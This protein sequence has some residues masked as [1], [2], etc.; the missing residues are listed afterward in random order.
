MFVEIA[1]GYLLLKDVLNSNVGKRIACMA[2]AGFKSVVDAGKNAV[3]ESVE[4]KKEEAA[5]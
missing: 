2:T 4:E 3:A 1:V 5:E